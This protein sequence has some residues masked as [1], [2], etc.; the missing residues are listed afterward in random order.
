MKILFISGG[1]YK[2]GAP[3]AMM[4]L[5]FMLH[6]RSEIEPA[7]LTKKHNPINALCDERGF[8]KVEKWCIIYK[9]IEW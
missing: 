8:E 1:N 5:L 6:G 4:E 9:I 7:L 2:Y 3:N